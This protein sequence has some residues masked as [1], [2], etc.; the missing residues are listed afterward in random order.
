MFR[1]MLTITVTLL[2]LESPGPSPEMFKMRKEDTL[3]IGISTHKLG[4]ETEDVGI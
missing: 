3:T 1:I 2:C 4:S